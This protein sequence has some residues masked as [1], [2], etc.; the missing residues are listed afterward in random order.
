MHMKIEKISHNKI[1]VTFTDEELIERNITASSAKSDAP[2]VHGLLMDVMHRAEEELGF[3]AANARL[4]VEVKVSEDEP[5]V[6][7][8]TRLELTDDIS[9]AIRSARRKVR[10]KVRPSGAASASLICVSFNRIEDAISLAKFLPHENGGELY[11]YN[12]RYHLIISDAV[13]PLLSEFGKISGTNSVNIVTEHGKK[14][15]DNA[16]KTLREHF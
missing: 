15:A 12:E 1:K 16:L 10:L 2:W 9:D 5:M 3:S 7:Y 11:F 8:I 4:M 13:S 6:M 14:I